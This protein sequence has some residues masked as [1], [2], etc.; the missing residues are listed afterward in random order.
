[1]TFAFTDAQWAAVS[2]AISRVGG[3]ATYGI[4]GQLEADICRYLGSSNNDTEIIAALRRV[5]AEA[6]ALNKSLRDLARACLKEELLRSELRPEVIA[7]DVKERLRF[8]REVRECAEGADFSLDKGY[9]TFNDARRGRPP[10]TTLLVW[11]T[12]LLRIARQEK[13]TLEDGRGRTSAALADLML[14]LSQCAQAARISHGHERR[15][16]TRAL[17]Q[18]LSE[19]RE[20]ARA[21]ERLN[22]ELDALCS[23]EPRMPAHAAN[24]LRSPTPKSD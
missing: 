8:A 3:Q 7:N 15:A 23:P 2:E 13:W 19:Q 21:A 12:A 16:L 22:S 4:R 10:D 14:K 11:A 24:Y 5:S 1:M 18:A 9:R 17:A 6:H 20:E